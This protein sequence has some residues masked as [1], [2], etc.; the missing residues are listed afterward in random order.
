MAWV[1]KIHPISAPENLSTSVRYRARSGSHDPQMTYS[2]NI[3]MASRVVAGLVMVSQV[4]VAATMIAECTIVRSL[5]L[6]F[7]PEGRSEG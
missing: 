3:M 7:G 4:Q 2:R 6:A 1:A 5:R